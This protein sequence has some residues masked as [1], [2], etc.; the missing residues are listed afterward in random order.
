M[1]KNGFKIARTLN[2]STFRIISGL[3]CVDI[4]GYLLSLATSFCREQEHLYRE[5]VDNPLSRV[6]MH[7]FGALAVLSGTI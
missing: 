7:T 2:F 5:S 4:S 1:P 3:L 6:W